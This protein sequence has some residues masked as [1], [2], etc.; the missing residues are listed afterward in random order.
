MKN[1]SYNRKISDKLTV[2]GVLSNDGTKITYIDDD[3]DEQIVSVD[4]CVSHFAGQ[5]ITFA[6]TL[7]KDEDLMTGEE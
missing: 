5:S 1:Y 2:K 7:N 3:K 4:E 6:I